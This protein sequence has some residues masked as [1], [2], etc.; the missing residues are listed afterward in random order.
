MNLGPLREREY[1]FRPVR[2]DSYWQSVLNLLGHVFWGAVLFLSLATV[3]WGIGWAVSALH[4][5][6]AFPPPVL[7]MLHTG[8]VAILYLDIG[9]SG[10]VL[11]VGAFRFIREITE[12]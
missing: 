10:I 6:H 8:E 5:I 2:R 12:H 9:L 4:A 3:S 1:E 11:L 7:Q